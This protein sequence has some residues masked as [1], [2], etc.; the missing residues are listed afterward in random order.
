MTKNPTITFAGGRARAFPLVDNRE[1]SIDPDS[2]P[3]ATMVYED[4]IT[5][6]REE[7]LAV[8]RETDTNRSDTDF[9]DGR[10]EFIDEPGQ[11]YSRR[12]YRR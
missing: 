5:R 9:W 12:V 8:L 7:G 4:P 11:H 1:V 10:V 2:P 6:Q 3:V